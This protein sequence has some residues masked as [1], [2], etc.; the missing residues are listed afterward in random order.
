MMH[1]LTILAV[2][3]RALYEVDLNFQF[4]LPII[5]FAAYGLASVIRLTIGGKLRY[6]VFGIFT[7]CYSAMWYVLLLDEGIITRVI[8]V[9]AGVVGLVSGVSPGIKFLIKK[10]KNLGDDESY[11]H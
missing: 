8:L 7:V 9:G 2:Y 4:Q 11:F 1:V 6:V 3:R 5:L 10:F